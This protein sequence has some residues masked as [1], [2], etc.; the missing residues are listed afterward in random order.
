MQSQTPNFP[1]RLSSGPHGL[2]RYEWGGGSFT[3][4]GRPRTPEVEGEIVATSH[5]VMTTLNGGARR[6]IIWNEDGCS[7]DGADRPGSVSFLPAGVCRRLVLKD[8]EWR[9]AALAIDPSAGFGA[10]LSQVPS[11]LA[12]SDGFVASLLGEFDRISALDGDL[13]P[14]WCDQMIGA[15]CAYLNRSRHAQKRL[16]TPDYRL[17]PAKLRRLFE[18]ID[19]ELSD[20]IR[21]SDLASLCGLS[22]GH[23]HRSFK[24]TTGKTPLAHV[25]ARRIERACHLLATTDHSIDMIAYKVGF[26]S[27]SHFA[28]LFR[29]NVGSAPSSYRRACR[30]GDACGD[31]AMPNPLNRL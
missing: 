31:N 18:F 10:T 17:S 5:L 24:L 12:P 23:F 20:V 13:D 4:A 3:T 8:V 28:R 27:P 30:I 15:L 6:H 21:T 11:F 2:R 7:F 25:T 1:S 9:W 26:I 19:A 29:Q 14:L 16:S 22:D